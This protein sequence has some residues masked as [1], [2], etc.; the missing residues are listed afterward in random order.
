MPAFYH[1]R[2]KMPRAG[3]AGCGGWLWSNCRAAAPDL[4]QI[5]RQ[6]APSDA[7][8]LAVRSGRLRTARYLSPVPLVAV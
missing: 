3:L 7:H 1:G 8:C 4:N 6:I 5:R 2:K